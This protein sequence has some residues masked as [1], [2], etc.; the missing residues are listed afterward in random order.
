MNAQV[1]EQ[2][3][4]AK[5]A[6]AAPAP[7]KQLGASAQ[8]VLERMSKNPDGEV[9]QVNVAAIIEAAAPSRNRMLTACWG[10]KIR[11]C[12]RPPAVR[13]LMVSADAASA[14]PANAGG[15]QRRSVCQGRG[16]AISGR[17][18]QDTN[19]AFLQGFGGKMEADGDA[20]HKVVLAW[21]AG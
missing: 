1:L 6:A 10:M 20:N 14:G 18:K 19:V 3:I 7:A 11:T 21:P 2:K 9:R 17:I 5:D 4:V 13:G 8:P 15:Q 12:D 16:G